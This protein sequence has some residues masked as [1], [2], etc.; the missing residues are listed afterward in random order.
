[1]TSRHWIAA[2]LLILG[3]AGGAWYWQTQQSPPE[4][5]TSET[6][7]DITREQTEAHMRQI[8][9]VQ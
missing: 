5:A 4:E 9:Y 7:E 6:E 8:G 3:T 1:M 2:G